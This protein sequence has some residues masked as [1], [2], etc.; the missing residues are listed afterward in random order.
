MSKN[1]TEMANYAKIYFIA[2]AMGP[3]W[4]GNYLNKNNYY[5]KCIPIKCKNLLPYYIGPRHLK[6]LLLS[7]HNNSNRPKKKRKTGWFAQL[8]VLY[9]INS[10]LAS[11]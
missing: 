4:Q 11:I 6:Q 8:T 3:E 1:A 9:Y 2:E 10:D 7:V 5:N